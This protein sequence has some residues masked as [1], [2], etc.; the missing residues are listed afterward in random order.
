MN[1]QTADDCFYLT[2]RSSQTAF[3]SS[4]CG[5]T[6]SVED[7]LTF[8]DFNT[9]ATTGVHHRRSPQPAASAYICFTFGFT[10][11]SKGVLCHHGGLVAFQRN[12]EVRL[13]AE[14]GC[15]IAQVMSPAF[16]G[17]IHELFSALSYGATLVLPRPSD[18]ISHLS[19]ATSAILTPSLAKV[20]EPDD[21]PRLQNVSC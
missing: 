13:Y 20:L 18:V 1:Y 16:D 5:L 8:V 2:S 10:G 11:K 15:R 4:V 14:P 19:E 6:L 17:S 7:I 3:A 21:Y 12:K 9:I